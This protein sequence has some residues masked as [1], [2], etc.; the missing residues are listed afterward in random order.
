MP[1]RSQ[2]RFNQ[3]RAM[4]PSGRPTGSN[5]ARFLGLVAHTRRVKRL[6]SRSEQS[7]DP[8]VERFILFHNKRHPS[9]IGPTEVWAFLTSRAVHR[10]GLSF[11]PGH[12]SRG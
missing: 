1:Q 4:V 6:A 3:H 7:H 8:W 12:S 10:R 11:R 9:E 5:E 2:S